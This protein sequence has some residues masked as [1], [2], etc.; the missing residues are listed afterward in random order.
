MAAAGY[1]YHLWGGDFVVLADEASQ[2][3]D[4]FAIATAQGVKS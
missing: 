2:F 4:N 1:V 3:G